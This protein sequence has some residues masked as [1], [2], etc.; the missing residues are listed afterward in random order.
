MTT[1]AA[2][3]DHLYVKLMKRLQRLHFA[4]LVLS[5]AMPPLGPHRHRAPGWSR[6]RRS[7]ALR[8][9]LPHFFPHVR[10]FFSNFE[11]M[12]LTR[13]R[14]LSSHSSQDAIPARPWAMT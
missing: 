6:S 1:W 10:Y 13:S 14:L 8:E 3:I 2:R 12:T 4:V 7:L 5:A 11:A 9:P